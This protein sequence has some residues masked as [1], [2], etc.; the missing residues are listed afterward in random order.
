MLSKICV[1]ASGVEVAGAAGMDL[2]SGFEQLSFGEGNASVGVSS[3]GEGV[4]GA[5]LSWE[6][7]GWRA[8]GREED[9]DVA[10]QNVA[11]ELLGW[12]VDELHV[13]GMF[14]SLR[15]DFCVTGRTFTRRFLRHSR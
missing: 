7:S 2:H 15:R 10:F 1:E 5:G 14:D 3:G 8:W 6:A 9:A 12:D 4:V 11:W 13:T